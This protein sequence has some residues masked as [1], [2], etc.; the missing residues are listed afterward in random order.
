MIGHDIYDEDDPDEYSFP[1]RMIRLVSVCMC[2]SQWVGECRCVW[3][4]DCVCLWVS[5]WESVSESVSEWVSEW[6]CERDCV[7]EW[8]SVWGSERVK[9]CVCVSLYVWTKESVCTEDSFWLNQINILSFFLSSAIICL[10]SLLYFCNFFTV[11]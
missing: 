10:F 6:V 8:V 4:R 11:F 3:E 1:H 2:V 7:C 9:G 5:E